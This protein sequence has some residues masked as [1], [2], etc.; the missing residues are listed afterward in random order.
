MS[1]AQR[2][3]VF[4]ALGASRA[5][6]FIVSAHPDESHDATGE[7]IPGRRTL[8]LKVSGNRAVLAE[9]VPAPLTRSWYSASGAA[10]FGVNDSGSLR[11][12]YKGAWSEEKFSDTPVSFI[13]Y[14]YAVPGETPDTDTL[15]LAS[16]QQIFI[17]QDGKWQMKRP[18]GE[19]LPYQID[20]SDPKQ[21]FIGG[22]EL[23]QWNGSKLTVLEAPDDDIIDGL[24][25]SA[26]DRLVG[27]NSYVSVSEADGGWRRIA[28]PT[29]R[30]YAYARWRDHVYTLSSKSGVL[31]VYPGPVEVLTRPLKGPVG[32]VA[33][34]DGLIALSREA[35][36]MFDGSQWTEI[37]IP[38]CELGKLP[39]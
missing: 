24:A 4:S 20:G 2:L 28:T 1:T 38:T 13:A 3:R 30:F 14:I 23:A 18:P 19:G 15:F 17:R 33:V 26:D 8:L 11:R 29:K 6:T 5:E 12:L 37:Q 27:G 9:E 39:Q 7:L 16:P 21:V 35:V 25:L 34:G 36:L 10:Y 31:R 32:L 22:S